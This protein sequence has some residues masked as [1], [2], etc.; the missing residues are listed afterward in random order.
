M[1]Y[2]ISRKGT[3]GVVTRSYVTDAGVRMA[4]VRWGPL[5]WLSPIPW[6][7]LYRCTSA[8]EA[9]ARLEAKQKGVAE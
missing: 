8:Y 2:V 4:V 7:E 6:D 1:S 9:E 3:F 5:G